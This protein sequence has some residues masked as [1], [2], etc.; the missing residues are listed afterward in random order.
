MQPLSPIQ[1]TKN[2]DIS[3]FLFRC[4]CKKPSEIIYHLCKR[5]IVTFAKWNSWVQKSI[6]VA[7]ST[8]AK[9]WFP[10]S[11]MNFNKPASLLEIHLT[12]QSKNNAEETWRNKWYLTLRFAPTRG[13]KDPEVSLSSVEVLSSLYW[14]TVRISFQLCYRSPRNTHRHVLYFF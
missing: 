3:Y 1:S 11:H 7:N 13:L 14:I 5:L 10:I 4:K 8:K 6:L 12:F 9:C 2:I